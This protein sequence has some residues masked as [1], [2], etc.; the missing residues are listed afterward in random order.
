[1]HDTVWFEIQGMPSVT[2]A[3]EEFEEAAN[4]QARALGLAAAR[5]VYVEH[6]IQDATDGEMQEKAE[7]VIDAV[8]QALTE[9][10]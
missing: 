5:C 4:I 8:V 10:D 9:A 1:M 7:K 6:P 3:S 2:V